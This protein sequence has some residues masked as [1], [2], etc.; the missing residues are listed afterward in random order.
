MSERDVQR[1]LDGLPTGQRAVVSAIALDGASIGETAQ[2][3]S[4]TPG[5]VRVALH[6]A[7]AAIARKSGLQGGSDAH[8]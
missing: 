3:L 6:R 5:A 7:L 1:H 8:R 4:M 2:R